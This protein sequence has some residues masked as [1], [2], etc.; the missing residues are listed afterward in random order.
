M[1]PAVILLLSGGVRV[2]ALLLAIGRILGLSLA[3]GGGTFWPHVPAFV[4][5]Y[6]A[7]APK[8]KARSWGYFSISAALFSVAVSYLLI[9]GVSIWMEFGAL[10]LSLAAH[11]GYVLWTNRGSEWGWW[12]RI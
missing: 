3:G 12:Q 1:H 8:P 11:L 5:L 9:D 2:L 7:F 10:V 4:L 6:F